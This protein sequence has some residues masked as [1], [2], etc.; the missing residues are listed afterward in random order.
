[1]TATVVVVGGGMSGL[2]AGIAAA[3]A[4]ADVVVLEQSAA[5]GGSMALSGGLI[6]APR[7]LPTARSYI[8]RGDADL[9]RL[10]VSSLRD[11]WH[12]LEEL[13]LPLSPEVDCLKDDMGRGRTMG[14]GTSGDRREF[15][16]AL[17]D[18]FARHGGRL[19]LGWAPTRLDR[20]GDGWLVTAGSSGGVERLRADAVV[21]AT[22]G[23]QNDVPLLRRYVTPHADRL[24]VRSN[25]VSAGAGMRLLLDHGAA[26]STGMSSFYG[27]S[28]P[29][30]DGQVRPEDF[31]PSS[32]YYSD[33]C[34]LLN[35]LGLR[36]TDESIGV[37]DEHNAQAG[38]RQPDAVYYLVFDEAIREEHVL[39]SVGL[40]GIVSSNVA[41][42]LDFVR[43]LGGTV[44]EAPTLEGLAA[45]LSARG[46]P[47]EN[48][49]DSLGH[50]NRAA[51]TGEQMFPPRTRDHVALARPPF[52]AVE[53]VA[54][55]TYTMGGL[56]VDGDCRVRHRD[57]GTLAGAYAVGADAGGV[58]QDVYGGGLAWATVTGRLAGR[59]AS[60]SAVA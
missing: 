7:D 23:F 5:V 43:S 9:Q 59:S 41:D 49:L 34:V 50:Y 56:A 38:S 14:L 8:P 46:V 6:W 22:G 3:Q 32:Q 40:P 31:I 19:L 37:L 58:F 30:V 39:G 42:R 11:A 45:A 15:A 26:L 52:Y 28:L 51:S 48:V 60:Q 13:G 25:P 12:W 4:G 29:T 54:A 2:C 20:D 57:G 1:V 17:A 47:A 55:I 27:H 21:V 44:L 36:F 16:T 18:V 53:C 24:V 10:L 35:R 33:Y